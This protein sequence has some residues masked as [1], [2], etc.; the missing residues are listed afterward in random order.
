MKGVFLVLCEDRSTRGRIQTG[1]GP[2]RPH[3]GLSCPG[4]NICAALVANPAGGGTP[5]VWGLGL[6]RQERHT[7]QIVLLR[8]SGIEMNTEHHA[9][10]FISISLETLSEIQECLLAVSVSSRPEGPSPHSPVTPCV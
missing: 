10:S 2:F 9:S 6:W 3:W 4:V 5:S 1:L 8:C 7:A